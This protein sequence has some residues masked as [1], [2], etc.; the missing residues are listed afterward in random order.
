MVCEYSEFE[1]VLF[2]KVAGIPTS[3]K[4]STWSFI[5]EIRGEITIVTPEKINAGI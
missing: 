3:F 1:S 4:A 2:I 5:K